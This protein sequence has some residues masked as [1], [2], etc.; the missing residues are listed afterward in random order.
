MMKFLILKFI[1]LYQNYLSPLLGP[2]CRFHP[3]CSEYALQAIENFGVIKGGF[4]AIKRI[5]KC[6]PWGGNGFDPIPKEK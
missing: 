4:L 5:L 3:T 6:N 1:K 2:S